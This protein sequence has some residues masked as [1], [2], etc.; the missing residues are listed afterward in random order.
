MTEAAVSAL[1]AEIPEG[2]RAGAGIIAEL[3]V[4][5]DRARSRATPTL[6]AREGPEHYINLERFGASAGELPADRWAYV[7]RLQQRGVSPRDGGFLPYAVMEWTEA[8]TLAFAELRRAPTDPTALATARYR[9]GWLAHYSADLCQPLHTTVDHDGRAVGGRSPRSGIH[10]RADALFDLI[11][12]GSR[13]TL[14]LAPMPDLFAGILSELSSSHSLVDRTYQTDAPEEA[15]APSPARLLFARERYAASVRF[16]ASLMLTAW[17]RSAS[18]A[19][20]GWNG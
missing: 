15:A 17:H 4:D 13:V 9:A 5:P 7:E 18:V 19:R 10:L 14:P 20:P 8:L 12:P 3:S 11:H 1:P 6:A 16:T 2:F